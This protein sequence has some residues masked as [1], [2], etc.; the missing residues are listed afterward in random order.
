MRHSWTL[1][2]GREIILFFFEP[3]MIQVDGVGEVVE[4]NILRPVHASQ[5]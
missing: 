5:K 2:L 3:R 4:T 1:G